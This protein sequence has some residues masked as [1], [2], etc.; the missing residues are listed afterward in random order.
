MQPQPGRT[1][2]Y[3]E[4]N[5]LRLPESAFTETGIDGTF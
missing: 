2:F 5:T 4:T 3:K 1:I